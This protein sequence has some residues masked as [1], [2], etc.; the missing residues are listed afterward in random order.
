MIRPSRSEEGE[1]L[2]WRL[3]LYNTVV[4]RKQ[5]ACSLEAFTSVRRG[6]KAEGE[7]CPNRP[8]TVQKTVLAHEQ[9]YP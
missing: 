8:R 7:T 5:T 2:V 1:N 9:S 4:P 6:E 3:V